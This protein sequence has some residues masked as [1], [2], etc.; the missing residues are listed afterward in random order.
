MNI[1]TLND[2]FFT[3]VGRNQDRVML[4][5]ADGVWTPISAGQLNRWVMTTA[6]QLQ[7]WGVGQGDRV[8]ILS[9]N[10]PEWAVTDFATLLLGGIVVPIYATQTAEQ[11]LYLFQH[12]EARIAFVSTR[13]QY[14]K[15][16]SIH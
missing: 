13:Q 16:A 3:V 7:A 6:R 14:E 12:S 11:V 2:V 8:V 10:R 4:S 5:R 1:R 9:E 15:V